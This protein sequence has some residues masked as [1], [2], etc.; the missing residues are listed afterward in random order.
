M[1]SAAVKLT[2]KDFDPDVDVRWCP[3][4]GDYAILAN[5]QRT[6]PTFGV[7]REKFVFVSGIGCAARFPYYMKT[8]GFHTIHG[9]AA[10]IATGLRIA[11]PDL[12][13]WVV[14]GDGDALAIGGNHLIHAIR[15]NIG[16]KILVFNNKVYGLTKGQYSPTSE[17]GTQ[18]PSTPQGSIDTPFRPL[19]VALGCEATFVARVADT[20]AK[21]MQAVITAAHEHKGTAFVEILQNCPVFND[22]AWDNITSKD[23]KEQ[24][25]LPLEHGKPMLFG[26]SGRSNTKQRGIIMR[27]NRM[28]VATVGEGGVTLKDVLVHNVAD[29]DPSQAFWLSRFEAPAFPI[30][31]GVYRAVERPA[32]EEL[33]RAQMAAARE[34]LGNG[35]LQKL[36]R[37]GDSWTVS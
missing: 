19:S 30:P 16:I 14:S 10:A 6:L 4:C 25:Q 32:Y 1:T 8:Y 13:V 9:R 29:P 24:V 12:H 21:M 37:A 15:R 22:G 28:A 5:L 20:D 26:A 33:S 7:P 36:L 18:G 3:G 23:A 31:M 27:D 2:K 17:M 35:D 11:R 34:K